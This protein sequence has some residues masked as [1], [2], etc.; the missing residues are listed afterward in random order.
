MVQI[1]FWFWQWNN[2]VNW[3]IFDS[4]KLRRIKMVPNFWATCIHYSLHCSV[5]R[6]APDRFAWLLYGRQLVPIHCRIIYGHL[7]SGMDLIIEIIGID[8]HSATLMNAGHV[9]HAASTPHEAVFSTRNEHF[10]SSSLCSNCSTP[11][12]SRGTTSNS[13]TSSEPQSR[14]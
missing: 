4:L 12:D 10:M 6:C 3:L 2:F 14:L 8:V 9:H 11:A 7:L 1:F 5:Y 13:V